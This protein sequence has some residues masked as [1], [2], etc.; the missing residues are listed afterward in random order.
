MPKFNLS[1]ILSP[2]RNSADAYNSMIDM[3]NIRLSQEAL[4]QGGSILNPISYDKSI[5]MYKSRSNDVTLSTEQRS[6]AKL[7]MLDM[8]KRQQAATFEKSAKTTS[9]N[10][11]AVYNED[12]REISANYP[13]NPYEYS[14]W[15]ALAVD[16]LLFGQD[17]I[18]DQIEHLDLYNLDT[19]NLKATRTALEADSEKY[20]GVIEAYEANDNE[21]L[22]KYTVVY[23]VDENKVK[24]MNI[25]DR[26]EES[27]GSAKDTDMRFA[28]GKDGSMQTVSLLQGKGMRMAL[29]RSNLA[30]G[31]V[32]K[33]GGIDFTFNGTSFGADSEGKDFHSESI[34]YAP[35][36]NIKAG[37]FARS[38]DGKVYY[39]N[40]DK[41]F[42][43][44]TSQKMRDELGYNESD[45]FDLTPSQEVNTLQGSISPFPE[46]LRER[47]GMDQYVGY[48]SPEFKPGFFESD[49]WQKADPS[50]K[51][52]E[53]GLDILKKG[54]AAAFEATKK[55]VGA[56]AKEIETGAKRAWGIPQ[57]EETK[58]IQEAQKEQF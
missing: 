56:V 8:Q 49:V 4:N 52:F 42:S 5:E 46:P 45:V 11:S 1:S 54:G 36:G 38:A 51:P 7:R 33:F 35:V 55:G 58:T 29:D 50:Y 9:D 6:D 3:D 53:K 28:V 31:D 48:E 21:A 22:Q 47:Y 24:R 23:S 14:R 19:T 30:A 41:T 32:I 20:N 26:H 16:K 40:T 12:L 10:I 37:S 15:A 43:P 25:I 34:R 18:N 44:I 27:Y 13:D 2:R 57:E 17:N 39:A